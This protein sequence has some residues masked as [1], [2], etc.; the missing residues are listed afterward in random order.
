MLIVPKNKPKLIQKLEIYVLQ[1][2][3]HA[4]FQPPLQAHAY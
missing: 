4:K 3:R 2:L 1:H